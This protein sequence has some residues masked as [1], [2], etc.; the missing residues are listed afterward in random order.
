MP[1][2]VPLR[3]VAWR[4]AVVDVDPAGLAG[5]VVEGDDGFCAQKEA[6]GGVGRAV[7]LIAIE[8][9]QGSGVGDTEDLA[10]DGREG[11]VVE[12]DARVGA[13]IVEAS[14]D[15]AVGH[16]SKS[17]GYRGDLRGGAV[18]AER[19]VEEEEGGHGWWSVAS[20]GLFAVREKLEADLAL[21][22]SAET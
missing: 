2:K 1:S 9:G 20:R 8:C 17:A 7:V 15:G 14:L 6:G 18:G 4:R 10:R 19:A 11:I 3:R 16:G 22:A 12:D 21:S 5:A 13:E